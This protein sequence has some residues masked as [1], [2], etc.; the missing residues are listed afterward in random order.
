MP[1][2]PIPSALI[3][4][5]AKSLNR[6]PH[7]HTPRPNNRH[8]HHP[9]DRPPGHHHPPTP[10]AAHT[11]TV[12]FLHGRGDNAH[13]FAR[14]LHA[15]RDSRG[16]TL[17]DTFPPF[18]WVLPQAPVRAS[19][20]PQ[21]PRPCPQW[22]DVWD[23]RDFAAREELQA[24][25]LREVVPLLRALVAREAEEGL[26]GRWDRVVLAGI[27]G[28]LAAFMGFCARCPFAGRTLQGMRQVLGLQ[29]ALEGDGVL[30]RTPVLLEHCVDDPL[31]LVEKGRGLRDTLRGFG[32]QVEWKEY[33]V[34]GHWFHE[35][36]EAIP[37]S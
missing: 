12:I 31:V 35:P 29:G 15:W 6:N 36:E 22:F 33:P 19:A 3:P 16:R 37:V 20:S 2:H 4:Q 9:G 34:G 11:H 13:A 24:A 26:G 18:R 5:A 17:F 32:M 21:M 25:G 7:P 28:G 27:R 30:R 10:P 23:V 1:A 8:V 14:G